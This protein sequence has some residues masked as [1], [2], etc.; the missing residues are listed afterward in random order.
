[1]DNFRGTGYLLRAE[2]I[3]KCGRRGEFELIV[4]ISPPQYL[5][6]RHSGEVAE[7]WKLWKE[8]YNNYFVISRLDRETAEFQ[9]AMFKHTSGDDALKVIK[10][11]TY[12]EEENQ[13]DWPVVM[14]KMEKHCIGEVNE[15]YERYCFN[16]RDKLPTESVDCFV[17][18]LKSL[19]KTCNFCNCLRDSL[20]RDRIVLGIKSEQTTKKLLRMSDLTLNRQCIDVCRSEEVAKLQMKSL[21]EPADTIHQVK[22]NK[23]SRAETPGG[24]STKKISCKFCGY[25][26]E[27]DRKKCPAW[28]KACKRCKEKN[29]FAKK[30]TK[31]TSVYNI[32]SEEEISGVRVQ[33]VKG[34]GVFAEMLVSQQPVKFQVDCGASANILPL[35]YAEGQELA[36]C[37]QTLVMWNGAK[38]KPVGTCALPVVNPKSDF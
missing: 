26:H 2:M 29:H 38:L 34:R 19:A 36:P 23:K 3:N 25:D 32:E 22:A 6:L 11:F 5:D 16:K 13:N 31:K 9:L 35:K 10:T 4:Y 1:M 37:S 33:A 18:E 24:R 21:S 7:N 15:I 20:I 30:C 27:L 12:T 17:A 14:G 28:G 8:K